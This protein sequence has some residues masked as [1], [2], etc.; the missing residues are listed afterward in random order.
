MEEPVHR[1]S[2]DK[3]WFAGGLYKSAQ[4]RTLP[5]PNPLANRR[6]SQVVFN[7]ISE[8]L[9]TEFNLLRHPTGGRQARDIAHR[10][11]QSTSRSVLGT[12]EG[13]SS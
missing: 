10:H 6:N 5:A 7:I 3:C 1:A 9:A 2:Q 12:S 8:F 11:F 4:V 13:F